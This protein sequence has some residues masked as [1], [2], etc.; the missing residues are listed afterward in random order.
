MSIRSRRPLAN[1]GCGNEK[2]QPREEEEEVVAKDSS[3]FGQR[4]RDRNLC[5]ELDRLIWMRYRA[6]KTTTSHGHRTL[7]SVLSLLS[8]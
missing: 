8:R 3:G 4:R 7:R 1:A 2:I 5:A 6:K